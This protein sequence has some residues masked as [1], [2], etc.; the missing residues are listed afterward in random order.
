MPIWRPLEADV[1][2]YKQ[3]LDVVSHTPVEVARLERL[4]ASAGFI[5]AVRRFI[6]PDQRLYS[7][8]NYRAR[9]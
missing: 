1:S 4:G 9:D 5:D 3:L 6:P 8:W 2:S 7:W